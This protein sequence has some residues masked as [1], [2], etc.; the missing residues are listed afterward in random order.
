LL[1]QQGLLQ[2]LNTVANCKDPEQPIL[3][4]HYRNAGITDFVGCDPGKK[5]QLLPLPLKANYRFLR[6]KERRMEPAVRFTKTTAGI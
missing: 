1:S 2:Y 6:A 4:E 3:E 5:V